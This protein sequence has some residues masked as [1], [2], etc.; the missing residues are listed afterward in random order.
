[1]IGPPVCEPAQSYLKQAPKSLCLSISFLFCWDQVGLVY[2]FGN[3]KNS[4]HGPGYLAGD[5]QRGRQG[6]HRGVLDDT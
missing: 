2:D 3:L 4:R 5:L 1:M 6:E